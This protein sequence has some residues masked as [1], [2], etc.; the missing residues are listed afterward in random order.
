MLTAVCKQTAVTYE[1]V[2]SKIDA[3]AAEIKLISESQDPGLFGNNWASRVSKVYMALL[4]GSHLQIF[5]EQV[6]E[7]GVPEIIIWSAERSIAKI[8]PK[9]AP[10]KLARWQRIAESA[11]K[12]SGQVLVPKIS[13][14]PSLKEA[15][16]SHTNSEPHQIRLVCSL[17]PGAKP[18][19][20]FE[21]GPKDRFQF[22]IGP[23][24]DFTPGE[25]ALISQSS[26]LPVTLGPIRLR[27]EMAG[28]AA[29][30][31]SHAVFGYF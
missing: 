19:K 4:K 22:I 5:L 31:S 21:V 24:G 16:L 8:E 17:N 2:L 3:S 29:V 12:Q 13:F 9:E 28:I 10:S 15:L 25:D 6:S 1:A 30:I 11:A 7:L 23:E 20:H 14:H 26:F 18:L 27:A